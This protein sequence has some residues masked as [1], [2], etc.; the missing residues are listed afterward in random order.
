MKNIRFVGDSIF[1]PY[2]LIGVG[3][4]INVGVLFHGWGVASIALAMT[5]A[6]LAS[7]WFA[8]HLPRENVRSL[9]RRPRNSCSV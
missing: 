4:L 2:F 5:V 1:V 3:M 8:A 7:K 9:P 6:A